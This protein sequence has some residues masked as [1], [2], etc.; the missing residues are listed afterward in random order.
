M[1]QKQT[2]R[3]RRFAFWIATRYLFSKKSHNAVNVISAISAIGVC[4]GTM[5]LIIVLSVFNGFEQ[6]IGKMFST[7]D[8][9]LEIVHTTENRF[10][11]TDTQKQQIK[12]LPTVY[13]FSEVVKEAGLV[14]YRERQI[15]VTIM[16]VSKTFGR[17]TGIDS[18]MVDGVCTFD[19]DDDRQRIVLGVGIAMQLGATARAI[20]PIS[21]YVPKR[22]T[23]INILRPETSINRSIVYVSGLFMVN[24]PEYDEK[25]V[26]LPLSLGQE[27]FEYPPNMVSSLHVRL[28]K[29]ADTSVAKHEIT[30]ILGKEYKALDRYEQHSE[31][32]KF[33]QIEKWIA[34]LILSF[35][36]MIAIFNIIGSLSLL[37]VEKKSDIMTLRSLGAT[38]SLIK[39]IFLSEGWLIT[40]IG[41]VI[42]AALGVFVVLL[43][44][45]F[46]LIKLS[47]NMIAAVDA[48]PILLSLWDVFVV[49]ITVVTISFLSVIYPVRH[50]ST[51]YNLD[52]K[53]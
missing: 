32:F 6:L 7:F 36:L 41:A 46:G 53:L 31:Y 10:L 42:G 29:N 49:L 2:Q 23:K 33:S 25:I 38:E 8:P 45:H 22:T 34:Y 17:V 52:K 19:D 30:S 40:T 13:E 35:I 16:G 5:A 27:L 18:I 24:Q 26:L 43:Q 3:H 44:Q 14:K 28:R 21:I 48:Y 1:T 47:E 37:I 20:A 39:L 9:D 50:L 15:P 4:V 11:L 12:A 51:K